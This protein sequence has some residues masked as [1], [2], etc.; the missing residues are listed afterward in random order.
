MKTLQLRAFLLISLTFFVTNSMAAA[1]SKQKPPAIA[2]MEIH[3]PA[4]VSILAD[5]AELP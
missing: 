4:Q 5:A 1:G 3:Q 2:N